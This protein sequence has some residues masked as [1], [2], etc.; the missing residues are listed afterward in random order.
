MAARPAVAPGRSIAAVPA[1]APGRKPGKPKTPAGVRDATWAASEEEIQRARR[2]ASNARFERLHKMQRNKRSVLFNEL[3]SYTGPM[4]DAV[5]K[6]EEVQLLSELAVLPWDPLRD[7][8]GREKR[9]PPS[10]LRP[11]RPAVDRPAEGDAFWA[12]IE[13][14]LA[15]N[16]GDVED[17]EEI[18][19]LVLDPARTYDVAPDV[20]EDNMI[21]THNYVHVYLNH[22]RGVSQAKL[23]TVFAA[24]ERLSV[25]DLS[26]CAQASDEVMRTIGSTS[27]SL[28]RASLRGLPLVSDEG[29]QALCAGCAQLEELALDGCTR[30]TDEA[31]LS[32]LSACRSLQML[33]ARD[34]AGLTDRALEHVAERRGALRQLDVRACPRLTPGGVQQLHESCLSLQ[35]ESSVAPDEVW[36]AFAGPQAW[37]VTM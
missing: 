2:M 12:A 13:A 18:D 7:D 33:S 29:I 1:V 35:I 26:G 24:S 34:V 11:D 6:G 16:D 10:Y 5:L 28:E 3:L 20:V 4:I 37:Y 8:P 19:E 30:L 27:A 25:L 21:L 22:A 31:V 23:L 14:G 15:L 32:V 17:E 36:P 9:P